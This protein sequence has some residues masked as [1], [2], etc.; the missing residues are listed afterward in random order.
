MPRAGRLQTN[1]L[2]QRGS[3]TAAAGSQ[4]PG[5]RRGPASSRRSDL[6]HTDIEAAEPMHVSDD[7]EDPQDAAHA[8]DHWHDDDD[9]SSPSHGLK[10]FDFCD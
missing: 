9:G 7:E 3:S 8:G 6:S 5:G 10:E 4:A 2:S 1:L